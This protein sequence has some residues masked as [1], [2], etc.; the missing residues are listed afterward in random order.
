MTRI[1]LGDQ[2]MVE[3]IAAANGLPVECGGDRVSVTVDGTEFYAA[4]TAEQM[5]VPA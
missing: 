4:K 5:A 2:N 1:N 3:S